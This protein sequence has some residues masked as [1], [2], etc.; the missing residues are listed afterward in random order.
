MC[1]RAEDPRQA[2][3]SAIDRLA[4]VETIQLADQD[5]HEHVIALQDEMS[6]LAAIRARL[7]AA[8]DGRRL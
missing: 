2:L 1:E 8:W 7:L 5:L 6:R 3:A 4:A